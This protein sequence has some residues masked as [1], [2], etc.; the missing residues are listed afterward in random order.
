MWWNTKGVVHYEILEKG[1][2]VDSKLYY[3]QLARF[4][5][6]LVRNKENP[7]KN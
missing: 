2:T 6:K 4:N 7:K 5:Q 1:E 3:Q